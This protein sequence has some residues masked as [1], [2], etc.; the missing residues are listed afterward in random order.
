MY[1]FHPLSMSF[2]KEREAEAVI[3]TNQC[4]LRVQSITINK[5]VLVLQ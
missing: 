3:S 2:T 5:H 1:D 4:A